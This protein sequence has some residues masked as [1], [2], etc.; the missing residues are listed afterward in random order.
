[1]ISEKSLNGPLARSVIHHGTMIAQAECEAARADA[2]RVLRLMEL[3][4]VSRT[5]ERGAGSPLFRD[6]PPGKFSSCIRAE[7]RHVFRSPQSEENF[8]TMAA[9]IR[10]RREGTKN[11]P[12]YRIVVTDGRSRREG[13]YIEQLGTYDPLMEG[14][15][16]S[17]D[18]EKAE[19]WVAKGAQPSRTVHNLMKSARKA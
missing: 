13:P 11:R 1:M 15:N 16:Y 7:A 4:P 6:M 9:V 2:F 18:V 17:I 3:E 19:G 12:Y 14:K 5:K 10:L 8:R